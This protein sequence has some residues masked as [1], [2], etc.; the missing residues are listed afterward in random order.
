MKISFWKK[1]SSRKCRS[2]VWCIKRV[3]FPS[4]ATPEQ[5]P[6]FAKRENFST[7]LTHVKNTYDPSPMGLILY[8]QG[9]IFKTL[10]GIEEQMSTTTVQ[11]STSQRKQISAKTFKSNIHLGQS[12][13]RHDI[14]PTSKE[15]LLSIT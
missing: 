12:K 14:F 6:M 4:T 5:K 7:E 15:Q 9:H 2:C 11:W 1:A 3:D 13:S 8:L 10:F